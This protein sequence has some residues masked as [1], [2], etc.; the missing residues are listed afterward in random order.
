M[1]VVF[2]NTIFFNQKYGGISRYFISLSEEFI[3]NDI[4][5]KLIAPI[6]KNRLLK[7]SQR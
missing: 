2:N 5:F 4:D 1:R 7:N 6:N 3:R